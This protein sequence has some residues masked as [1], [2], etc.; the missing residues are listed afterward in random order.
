MM[1]TMRNANIKSLETKQTAAL[2]ASRNLIAAIEQ[3]IITEQTK[4]G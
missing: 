4:D 1:H 3:G 2:K